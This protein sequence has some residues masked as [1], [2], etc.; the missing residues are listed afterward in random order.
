MN[1]YNLKENVE[2]L[3]SAFNYMM[4]SYTDEESN[5]NPKFNNLDDIGVILD[6]IFKDNRCKQVMFTRNIDN[7]FFGIR[8]NPEI[9]KGMVISI[10]STPDPIRFFKYSVPFGKLIKWFEIACT[11]K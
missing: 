2:R 9:T 5:I 3:I 4:S 6:S 7:G 11:G 1:E 8:I 10:I